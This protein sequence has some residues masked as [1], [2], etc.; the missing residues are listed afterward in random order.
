MNA[1]EGAVKHPVTTAVGVLFVLLFGTLSFLRIPVQLTPTVERPVITVTTVWPGAAPPEVER[2]IVQE[3]E[4]Q[5]KSL[6]ALK[7]M[8]SSS[9]L[10]QGTI[11]L[12]FKVGINID[13]ALVNVSNRLQ[14]VPR[15]PPD[16]LKPIVR[17]ASSDD[18][19]IA[20]FALIKLPEATASKDI[21]FY[22]DF[23]ED[24]VAPEFERVPGVSQARVVGGDRQE[25]HLVVDPVK[26]AARKITMTELANALD[27]ENSSVSGGDFDEG[28]N[29]FV[30][31]TVGEYTSPND[32]E[33][34]VVAMRDRVPVFARD[35]GFA[36]LGYAKPTGRVYLENNRGLAINIAKAPDANLLTVMAEL[37]RV[38]ERLNR[39]VLAPQGLVLTQFVDGTEYINSAIDL[40]KGS[41]WVGGLLA[42]AVLLLFLRSWTSTVVVVVA[43]PVS[44]VGTFLMM[45]VFGRSIN[46]ISLAG[47]AFAVGMVVDNAIVVLENID[48]HRQMGKSA[49]MAAL[50]GAQEV[51]GAVLASTLTTVAVFV[52][53]IFVQEEAGQLFRDI[54]L[55]ISCSVALS[56][57]VA[58]TVIPSLSALM[59]SSQSSS[60]TTAGPWRNLLGLVPLMAWG[61]RQMARFVYWICGSVLRRA[62]VVAVF[63]G[64]AV[65]GSI[66]M[67]P[68][69]EYLP[70]GNSNF[71]FGNLVLPSNY[72]LATTDSL[73][74]VFDDAVTPLVQATGEEAEK[75]PGGG[76]QTP[77]YVAS[78]N[79]AFMGGRARDPLRITELI[80][81]YRGALAKVPAAIGG[82]SQASLFQRGGTGDGIDLDITGPDF[83]RLREIARIVLARVQEALPDAQ[84][85]PLAGVDRGVPELRVVPHRQRSAE[86]GLSSR[87]LGLM[88]NALVD[89]VKVADYQWQGKRI[90]LT[91]IGDEGYQHRTHLVG[92]LPIATPDDRLVT[93][94]SVA[95]IEE[96]AG[97]V[98]IGHR[99][100]QRA[101][102]VRVTPPPRVPLQ[103][104]MEDIDRLV[105]EPLTR[106][107][108]LTGLYRI[109]PR[110]SADKL[111][112]TWSALRFNFLLAVLITY[113][114]MAALFESFVYP[115]VIMFSV[116]LATLGG[117]LGLWVMNLY[118]YQALDVL[119]ML[120]FFILVGTV[121]NNA[122]LI[123]HQ[124]LNLIRNEGM[125]ARQAIQAA[126]EVRVRPIFMSVLTSVLGMSPLVLI[127]GAG[128][129][130][131]R[132]IGSVVIG[133]M[134]VSTIFTLILIPTVL[135][136]VLDIKASLARLYA[137]LREPVALR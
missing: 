77:F 59:P 15:Y 68:K 80:P 39:L 21:A 126:T 74:A 113:L 133:G 122:I 81:V 40:V 128:S 92:Q 30:V 135:S 24:V 106:E 114:L 31:R 132:G 111:N 51:W 116:P 72:N 134:L 65:G 86:Y 85:R 18:A 50:H 53:V 12:T 112:E 75:L 25:M 105:I 9:A 90:D 101:T 1:I 69:V 49:A 103:T 84:A 38:N 11:T 110:G 42:V 95:T 57:A 107:G 98:S 124:T 120:G 108:V 82:F 94:D 127:P 67:V 13:T 93:L 44:I 88:V 7:R 115:F 41:V 28:K 131:Y 62:V 5:L 91:I 34:V 123:V 47:M 130:L 66:A 70:V 23:M 2:Q 129:E 104:V 63:V 97:P 117:F 8:V 64:V 58:L 96:T 71:L 109:I 99:E 45:D 43:M 87:E 78:A 119:T 60:R 76:M 29:R 33:N 136:L 89:G 125:A 6:Q 10:G 56:M 73:R 54:A 102:T 19:A 79:S 83:D 118:S 35:V 22:R 3:Q 26:L 37:K 52:P 27:R 20:W 100:R 4:E 14:Q 121:V 48:R 46:V 17:A 137:N 55:A 32:V 61:N 36:R 16:A